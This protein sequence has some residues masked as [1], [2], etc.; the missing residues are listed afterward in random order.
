[1][2]NDRSLWLKEA[3]ICLY[4]EKKLTH[5]FCQGKCFDTTCNML[6]IKSMQN[7]NKIIEMADKQQYNQNNHHINTKMISK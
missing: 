1:V 7:R 5:N 2:R 3:R 4:P 6:D